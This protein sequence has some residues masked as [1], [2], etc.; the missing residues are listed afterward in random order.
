M[1]WEEV[2]PI[3]VCCTAYIVVLLGGVIYLG[4]GYICMK[5]SKYAVTKK[6][7]DACNLITN[8]W[9]I[10]PPIATPCSKFAMTVLDENLIITGGIKN[11]RLSIIIYMVDNGK[12]IVRCQLPDTIQ[13]QTGTTFIKNARSTFELLDTTNGHWHTCANL[14]SPNSQLF[15]VV[16]DDTLYLLGGR[17]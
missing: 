8:Q 3:P 17:D 7:M 13:H 9:S 11:M 5:E 14:P 10:L 6:R 1:T 12:I 4:S 16:V 2:S 15:G